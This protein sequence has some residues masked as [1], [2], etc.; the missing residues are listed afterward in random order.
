MQNW[1]DTH[2]PKGPLRRRA[3]FGALL[4]LLALAEAWI[5]P[6]AGSQALSADAVDLA[7]GAVALLLDPV[8]AG[9][10]RERQVPL[11]V[12]RHGAIVALAGWIGL[13]TLYRCFFEQLPAPEAM[14]SL[15]V[16]AV[17]LNLAIFGLTPRDEPD[18]ALRAGRF[19]ARNDLLGSAAL[20]LAAGVVALTQSP[21]A[22]LVVAGVMMALVLN[23]A[24]PKLQAALAD[25]RAL[26]ADR[27]AADREAMR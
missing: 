12:L 26:R 25:L 11:V 18:T 15:G 24:V 21:A 17:A 5:G 27:P 20:L 22:D 9:M 4:L 10:K 7:A 19:R 3:G 6:M 16:M 13:S 23:Q 14:A 8:L 1:F 2:F